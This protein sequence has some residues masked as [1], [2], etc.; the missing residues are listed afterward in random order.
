MF[1]MEM[2]VEKNESRKNLKA[3]IPSK[4]YDRSETTEECGIFQIFR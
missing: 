1:G 3:T 2:N 4:D